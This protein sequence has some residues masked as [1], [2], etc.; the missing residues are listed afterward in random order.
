MAS[1][2]LSEAQREH[3]KVLEDALG[4]KFKNSE[5]VAMAL[6]G[7]MSSSEDA[8]EDDDDAESAKPPSIG[9]ILLKGKKR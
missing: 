9:A 8:E 1:C 2:K 5:R 7:V 3:L 6:R 4:V